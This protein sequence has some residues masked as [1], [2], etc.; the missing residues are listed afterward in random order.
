MSCPSFDVVML[1]TPNIDYYAAETRANW[2]SYCD[3]HGYRFICWREVLLSDLHVIWSKLEM[4]RKQM[5]QS[6][7]DWVLLVDADTIVNRPEMQLTDLLSKYPN[8]D[9]VISEDVSRRWGLPIPLSFTSVWLS[10]SLR[11]PNTGF[12]FIRNSNYGRNFLRRWIDFARTPQYKK[13]AA[14]HPRTQRVL[15]RTLFHT[16][17]S[18]I[19]IMGP[20]VR[21]VG[22]SRFLDYLSMNWE[23][24][25]VLHDKRLPSK[26]SQV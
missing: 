18:R 6:D 13:A 8:K 1:A 12:M 22:L 2:Q 21:R 5:E 19:G 14:T 10:K 25:F 11:P 17:R 20:E 9:I 7:A 3:R 16:D 15:W 23:K 24:A 4:L 26:S